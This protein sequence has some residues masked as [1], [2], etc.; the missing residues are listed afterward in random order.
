MQR[1][2]RFYH[3]VGSGY[4]L[5]ASLAV[6]NLVTVPF[7]LKNLGKEAFGVC[8]AAMQVMAFAS[9]FQMGVGPSIGRFIADYKDRRDSPEYGSFFKSIWLVTVAQGLIL[10]VA[11]YLLGHFF[12]SLFRIPAELTADFRRLLILN[13]SATALGIAV[14]PVQQLLFAH[15]RQDIQNYAAIAANL[16]NAGALIVALHQGLGLYSYTVGVWAGVVVSMLANF[17]AVRRLRLMPVLSCRPVSWALL[18][19]MSGFAGNVLF[20][21]MGSQLIALSPT[22]LVSRVLGMNALADWS[23]GTRLL[24]LA[25]QLVLRMPA[26]SEP[27]FWE[28][29]SR[30]EIER[31]RIRFDH[32]IGISVATAA[33]VGGGLVAVNSIFVEIWTGGRVMWDWQNDAICALWLVLGTLSYAWNMLPAITK[34]LGV[35]KFVYFGEGLLVMAPGLVGARLSGIHWVPCIMVCCLALGRL[36][37]GMLRAQ[38]DLAT[39]CRMALGRIG[40]AVLLL[41]ALVLAAWLWRQV[42]PGLEI[43]LRFAVLLLGYF[44][45]AAPLAF[46]FGVPVQH[47][48]DLLVRLG[49]LWR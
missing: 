3:S 34:R 17:W 1:S 7:A 22:V 29:Y 38:G 19:P 35:M 33:L 2:R 39:S 10:L 49:K 27:A 43:R 40:G 26:A 16:A 14:G 37:Y 5:V 32:V 48:S 18:R 24:T 20:I 6:L 15:Q 46:R 8:M 41:V 21:S 36:L 44:V 12:Q 25:Q 11:S 31:F 28:M 30:G 4:L 9:L 47:R 42:L 23:V 45:V 13:L